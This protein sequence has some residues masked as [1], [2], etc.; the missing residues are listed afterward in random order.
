MYTQ[1]QRETQTPTQT[2]TQAQAQTQ[3]QTQTQTQNSDDDAEEN[4]WEHDKDE[5]ENAQKVFF[6][7]FPLSVGF[8]IFALC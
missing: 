3:T 5:P 6:S 1:A 4:L 2:Q 7:R 8:V